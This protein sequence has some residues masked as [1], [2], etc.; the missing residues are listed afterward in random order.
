MLTIAAIHR[1]PEHDSCNAQ[2]AYHNFLAYDRCQPPN[3]DGGGDN[4]YAANLVVDTGNADVAAEGE[5]IGTH[6]DKA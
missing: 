1:L 2:A 3:N 4:Q 6:H 5:N